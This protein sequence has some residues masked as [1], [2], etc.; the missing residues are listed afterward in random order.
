MSEPI[1][2]CH[3]CNAELIAVYQKA[4]PVRWTL[5]AG[6]YDLDDNNMYD[7]QNP[8]HCNECDVELNTEETEYVDSHMM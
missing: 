4:S 3:A 1:P 7:D 8:Y 2:K 6:K 5:I